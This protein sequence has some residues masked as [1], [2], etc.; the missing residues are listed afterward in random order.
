MTLRY[1]KNK[2]TIT[3]EEQ[4]ILFN[5]TITIV[6]CGGLGQYVASHFARIGIGHIKIIDYDVFE[7]TNLNRQLFSLMENIGELKVKVTED[8]LKRINPEIKITI[9]PIKFTEKIS[10]EVL[11]DSDIVI[12]GL[13]SIADRLLL[14]KAC[15]EMSLPLISAAIGG[16]YGYMALIRPGED[17]LCKLYT[18]S[19]EKRIESEL[20]NPAFTPAILA[21]FEVSEAIKYLLNRPGLLNNEILFIDLLNLTFRRV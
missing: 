4:I 14:Q 16:W 7:E 2:K 1:Q 11:K 3:A 17:L 6:G 19:E 20:G 18:D 13:D 21:G 9:F 15:K 12:D 10:I 5:K 8:N